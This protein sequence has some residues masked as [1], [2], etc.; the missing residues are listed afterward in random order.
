MKP[1]KPEKLLELDVKGWAASSGIWLEVYD[2]KA[3]LTE[4]GIYKVQGVKQGTPDLLGLN[5]HGRFIAIELKAPKA[6]LVPSLDQ[7]NFLTKVIEYGGFG[8]V[9]NN[10]HQ[11]GEIYQR[12]LMTIDEI[13]KRAYL[14]ELLPNKVKIKGKIIELRS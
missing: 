2:S 6:P 9:T 8:I 13:N 1:L 3:K 7:R 14:L 5:K 10:V 12:W 11:L 4:R